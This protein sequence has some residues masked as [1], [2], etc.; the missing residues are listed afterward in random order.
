M[1]PIQRLHLTLF[2]Y[3]QHNRTIGRIA[4]IKKGRYV[5]YHCSCAK[6]YL[7]EEVLEAEFTKAI[8]QLAFNPQFLADA[9][10]ALRQSHAT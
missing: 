5:Y 9:G 10:V 3:T 1:R 7:R 8:R 4:E 6:R 2:V